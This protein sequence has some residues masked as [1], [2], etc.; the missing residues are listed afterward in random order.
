LVADGQY[1]TIFGGST[2]GAWHVNE[3]SVDLIRNNFGAINNISI[4]LSGTP[5][6]GSLSQTFNAVQGQTYV[7]S[8]D[9]FKNGPG[10]DLS[11]GF[12]G[13]TFS[14]SPPA[15]V[16]HATLSWTATSTGVQTVSFGG[17]AGN[18]GPVLDNVVLVTSAV[19]EPES[20]ALML[21]GL[22][23]MGLLARRRKS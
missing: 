9:Y 12:G 20:Y 15:A 14:Y 22:A 5:G 3:S 7:L 23:A 21:A 6:P 16:T 1:T 18:Q 4:D 11:V 17:G 10:T 13:Q 8:W 19:P 2:L